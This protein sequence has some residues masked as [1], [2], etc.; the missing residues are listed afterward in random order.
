MVDFYKKHGFEI[1]GDMFKE[2]GIDHYPMI[3][4]D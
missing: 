1:I 2:A 3:R 4:N